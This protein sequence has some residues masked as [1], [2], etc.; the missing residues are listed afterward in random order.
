MTTETRPLTLGQDFDGYISF[1]DAPLE[2]TT[3]HDSKVSV[4]NLYKKLGR[5]IPPDVV[6]AKVRIW[7]VIEGKHLELSKKC[8]GK[9]KMF[10]G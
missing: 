3:E 1:R 4:D 9:S 8:F 7:K 5:E 10:S 6:I 2:C